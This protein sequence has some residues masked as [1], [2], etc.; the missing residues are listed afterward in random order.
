MSG[1]FVVQAQ[2]ETSLDKDQVPDRKDE[3]REAIDSVGEFQKINVMF[4]EEKGVES[5]GYF[6]KSDRTTLASEPGNSK[7]IGIVLLDPESHEIV[8]EKFISNP[9][10]KVNKGRTGLAFSVLQ[11]NGVDEVLLTEDPD[12]GQQTALEEVGLDYDVVKA[13]TVEEITEELT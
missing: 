2:S 4:Q 10:L 6:L 9:A 12:K 7:Y 1:M 8:S 3:I 11:K 5:R 13:T